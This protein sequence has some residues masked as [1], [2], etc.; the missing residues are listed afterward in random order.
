MSRM[1]EFIAFKATIELLKERG[2]QNVI[3]EVYEKCVAQKN[4]KKEEIVNYVKGIYAPFKDEEISARLR[5]C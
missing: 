1:S 2:M 3:D 4:K 5:R